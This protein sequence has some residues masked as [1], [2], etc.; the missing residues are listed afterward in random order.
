MKRKRSALL[1][2]ANGYTGRLIA[3]VAKR[4]GVSITLAGRRASAIEPVA[5]EFGCPFVVFSL[6]NTAEVAKALRPFAAFLLAAGPFSQTSRPALD[7]CMKARTAYLDITGEIAVFEEIFSRQD[8]AVKAGITVMPG[9]GFDV[10]PSDCLARALAEALPGA[11]KLELAFRGFKASA[12]TLKTM[13]EGA[14]KGGCIR[15][16][17]KLV[18][19]AP[20]W[21]VQEIPFADKRRLAV[22]IPW[23]DLSTAFRSTGIPNIEVYMS[24]SKNAIDIMKMS[25]FLGGALELRAMQSVMKAL[26]GLVAQGPSEEE[27]RTQRS[28]LWGRVTAADGRTTEGR[29]ETL[30]GYSLTAE[31]A[32]AC[33]K[34]VLAGIPGPGVFTPSRAFGSR[35]VEKIQTTRMEILL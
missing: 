32:V 6:E 7:A 4:E 28:F 27:R 26:A 18:P 16:D 29:L 12:G 15:Q 9:T 1:Y 35:F 33:L 30:E 20:A 11:E 34:Q 17:G 14:G 31:T 8:E 22:S 3:A 2:G 10:V 23:G 13:I 19:V 5:R 24:M 21:K 25:R